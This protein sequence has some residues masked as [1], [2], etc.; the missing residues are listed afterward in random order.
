MFFVPVVVAATAYE[1]G[2]LC[3]DEEKRIEAE[4]AALE[5][6]PETYDCVL[7]KLEQETEEDIEEDEKRLK[8]KAKKINH[9][10]EKL[11]KEERKYM[12]M[13]DELGEEEAIEAEIE[14]EKIRKAERELRKLE[15]GRHDEPPCKEIIEDIFDDVKEGAKTVLG[16]FA[17]YAHLMFADEKELKQRERA[18]ER[19]DMLNDGEDDEF[20]NK[21]KKK[22]KE[23]AKRIE[24][25][26]RKLNEKRSAM[27]EKDDEQLKNEA[28]KIKDL[29][30]ELEIEEEKYAQIAEALTEELRYEAQIREEERKVMDDLNWP[31][32]DTLMTLRALRDTAHSRSIN[33]IES[34]NNICGLATLNR[35]QNSLAMGWKHGYTW[36]NR[37]KNKI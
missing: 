16:N 6:T 31:H 23:A 29:Q 24:D 34:E 20:E 12:E 4:E 36:E 14:E 33:L 28:R 3:Q 30:Q 10:Q 13:R 22:L 32:R 15:D 37:F 21:N 11:E 5:A 27:F 2:E 18:I 25:L 26:K 8:K 35:P 17:D 1:V 7:K 19:G 9:L